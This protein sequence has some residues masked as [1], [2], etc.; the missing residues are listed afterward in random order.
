MGAIFE[1]LWFMGWDAKMR[2]IVQGILTY[3]RPK[4]QINLGIRIQEVDKEL[5]RQT[6]GK[7]VVGR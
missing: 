2:K 3:C 4:P 5:S 6:A 7:A 1:A